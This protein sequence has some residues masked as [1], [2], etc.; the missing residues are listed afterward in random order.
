M[1]RL[2][3]IKK[4]LNDPLEDCHECGNRISAHDVDWLLAKCERYRDVLRHISDPAKECDGCVIAA[5]A[6]GPALE[7]HFENLAREALEERV[8]KGK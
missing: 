7:I 3:E 5:L 2:D 1:S 4:I 8:E 6:R